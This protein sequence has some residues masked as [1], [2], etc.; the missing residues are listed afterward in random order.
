MKYQ[1]TAAALLF[2]FL[3]MGAGSAGFAAGIPDTIQKAGDPSGPPAWISEDALRAAMDAKGQP[4]G[5]RLES[6]G[7]LF[8]WWPNLIVELDQYA[9]AKDSKVAPAGTLI[10]CEPLWRSY[11]YGKKAKDLVE[12]VAMSS[13]L[14][15][16]RVLDSK[17][18][19]LNGRPG[20][21]L[22]VE[23]QSI[24]KETSKEGVPRRGFYLFAHYTRMVIEG[25][26]LCLGER[27]IPHGEEF[28][29][30]QAWTDWRG[31]IGGQPI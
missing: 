28:L 26:A 2:S 17:A 14:T 19:F 16:A 25:R 15:R 1:T 27:Q 22:E 9:A 7:H 5:S 18:G 8:K 13:D 30:F 4:I 10:S 20:E 23:V 12:L 3:F 24:L 11:Y 31:V 6:V 21:M 29:L